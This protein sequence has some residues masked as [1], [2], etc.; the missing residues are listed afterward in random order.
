MEAAG[1]TDSNFPTHSSID[2]SAATV[3]VE[4]MADD[5]FEVTG[6]NVLQVR[7][8]GLGLAIEGGDS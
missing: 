1:P 6:D 8:L 2:E 5:P 4:A 7:G 3:L